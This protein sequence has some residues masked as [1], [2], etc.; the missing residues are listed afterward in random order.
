MKKNNATYLKDEN[1]L[2]LLSL[3][4]LIVP[5]IQ[6]E[7]V[8]GKIDNE[9]VLKRFLESLKSGCKPCS[10][11]KQAHKK[12]DINI[13]F[14][15]SYKPS[16]VT[17]ENE[18]YLDEFLIDGQQRFT[19]LFL[20]LTYLAIKENRIKD[21]LT[22]VRFDEISEEIN[23]DY[24]VRNITH[25]FLID[26]L[27][28][29]DTIDIVPC[30]VNKIWA[31]NQTWFLS[32]YSADITIQAMLGALHTI[33]EVFNDDFQYFDYILTA[34][35]FWHF[36]TEAT[37][38]GEE[39]Y[40]TMNSR[41]E[42]L[43]ENEE[44]KAAILP[45][46]DLITWGT[47]WE[48]WQDF[49]WKNRGENPN[50]DNGFNEFLNCIN[51]LAKYK[52]ES[53]SNT[54]AFIEP[55]YNAI[56]RLYSY[57]GDL[58]W[59]K[60]CVSEFKEILNKKTN[61][62][63]FPNNG[64]EQRRMVFIWFIMELLKSKNQN[65]LEKFEIRA[66]RFIWVRYNNHNRA[67][68]S[69]S[70]TVKM[71]KEQNVENKSILT[72]E[73]QKKYSYLNIDSIIDGD[74][75]EIEKLVWQIEDHPL[76]ID[77]SDLVAINISHIVTFEA[78]PTKENLQTIYDRFKKIFPDEKCNSEY[79]KTLKTLLLHYKDENDNAFWKRVSPWYYE[80]YD[81]SDWRR[82][83]R[84]AIFKDAFT[85]I[86]NQADT[87][88]IDEIIQEKKKSFYADYQNID[89]IKDELSKRKQLII[90]SDLVDIWEHG[91]IAFDNPLQKTGQRIF[92]NEQ[93]IYTLKSNFKNNARQE[94]WDNVKDKNID[95]ELQN[96]L[97][98]YN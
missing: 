98:K 58:E 78:N 31:L 4:N 94:L 41:G 97:T 85:E 71:W 7:Y 42:R 79:K 28:S 9:K 48:D 76:N 17:L 66:L 44:Q 96:I 39:L 80:N 22:L 3:N 1:L 40:I 8:W 93:R 82:I 46:K 35:R 63:W 53:E 92:T 19:T 64:T 83:I 74:F 2:S 34:V 59:L 23:F 84:G 16:Y 70:D 57:N 89:K 33:S 20:L 24:K 6:R 90:Y 10:A 54:P 60:N 27:S 87:L 72:E 62:D 36:K 52:Q 56:N 67:V 30:E 49:F 12:A 37:S 18:R 43:A 73:E 61:T 14:L 81:C 11:C 32:D 45:K 77:G 26:L 95:D 69:I 88:I 91:N 65:D 5:E 15:Y 50:A 25:K 68:M 13:G 38:Q 21:F 86:F 47:K 55:Y 75:S 51:G 29:L